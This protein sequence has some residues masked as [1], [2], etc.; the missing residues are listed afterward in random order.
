MVLNL[1][2]LVE[3]A[4]RLLDQNPDLAVYR[5]GLISDLNDAYLT[6][7]AQGAFLF[8]QA[9]ATIT[10]VAPVIGSSA[11]VVS[12]T[13]G[14]YAVTITGTTG[15][16][17]WEGQTF[18][19]PDGV[20]YTIARYR[21]LGGSEYI[22]LTEPYQGTTESSSSWQVQFREYRLP[23]DCEEVISVVDGQ[24]NLPI[25]FVVR[26]LSEQ[27]IFQPNSSGA[28]LM[29]VDTVP[30]TDRPPDNAPT[31]TVGNTAPNSLLATTDYDICY[32]LNWCGR[33]SPPSPVATATTTG[34]NKQILLSDLEDTREGGLLTGI[35]KTV[36]MR[37]VTQNG[38]WLKVVDGLIETDTTYSFAD[39]ASVSRRQTNEL[40][41]VSPSYQY[42]RM[43]PPAVDTRIMRFRY[44]RRVR[45]LAADA[46]VPLIPPP[47]QPLIVYRALELRATMSGS[48]NTAAVFRDRAA[49]L[50]KR[51]REHWLTR[52]TT[53]AQRQMM[54]LQGI[55]NALGPGIFRGATYTYSG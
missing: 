43:H 38:R 22:Y 16:S 19:G 7:C 42:V 6:L 45:K 40:T 14:T 13:N 41:P 51:M 50:E 31:L 32:T 24:T 12:V 27:A 1:F 26:A 21:P 8:L 54:D 11:A 48:L 47:Y 25:P 35:F 55:P 52:Q 49:D 4:N 53:L 33:E 39:D 5:D 18:I 15:A 37:N 3:M 36:Y 44:Q 17:S 30:H 46:D 9:D 2:A 28:A 20:E 34:T 23:D 29:A 10:M